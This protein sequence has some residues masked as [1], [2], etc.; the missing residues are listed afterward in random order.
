MTDRV[1]IFGFGAFGALAARTLASHAAVVV[2][3][4]AANPETVRTTGAVPVSAAE[5]AASPV[6]VLAVPVQAIED[7]CKAIAPAL[8]EGALVCDVASVKVLPVRWMLGTLPAHTQVLGTHPLFGPETAAELGGV[9]GEPIALCKPEGRPEDNAR[10][11]E[12]TYARVRTFLEHTLGLRVIEL[13]P[14]EHDQQMALV[15]GVTHLIGHAAA[16]MGLPEL[17]TATLAYRRLLQLKHNTERDAPAMTR[18]IQRLNP[19]AAGARR[20]FLDAMTRADARHR[21]A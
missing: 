15:Q 7:V 5:A 19:H 1:G 8:A 20:A 21:E 4:P 2:H 6:V 12:A 11:D 18:A 3:D 13:S 17:A 9:A 16:E 10:L 14:D